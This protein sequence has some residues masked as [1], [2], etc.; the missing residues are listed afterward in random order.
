M[1]SQK[2]FEL[3]N[4][5]CEPSGSDVIVVQ[6]MAIQ[7]KNTLSQQILERDRMIVIEFNFPFFIKRCNSSMFRIIERLGP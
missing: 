3:L 2:R 4:S 6:I 5:L 1:T 7:K